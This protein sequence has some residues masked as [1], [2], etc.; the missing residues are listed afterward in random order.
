VSSGIGP[1]SLPG[2]PRQFWTVSV[3]VQF[4]AGQFSAAATLAEVEYRSQKTRRGKTISED[5]SVQPLQ[6]DQQAAEGDR[7]QIRANRPRR[8][9]R[10]SRTERTGP[11][12]WGA[13]FTSIPP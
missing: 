3:L 4:W 10:G 9:G 1:L 6:P 11:A 13:R 2:P 12:A 7:N 5:P 8:R